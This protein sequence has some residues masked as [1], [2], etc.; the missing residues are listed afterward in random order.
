MLNISLLGPPASGKGTQAR[1][2][3]KHFGFFYLEMGGA[4]RDLAWRKDDLGKKVGRIVNREGTLVPDSIVKLVLED[5]F[6]KL[7]P[8]QGILIDGFP[9]VL[10]QIRLLNQSFKEIGRRLDFVILLDLPEKEV[11]KRITNRVVCQK[12][13]RIYSLSQE[14]KKQ[15]PACGGRLVKRFDDTPAGIKKRLEVFRK[16]TLPVINFY[17]REGILRK[18][19]GNQSVTKI[20]ERIAEIIKQSYDFD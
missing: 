5:S 4:L 12:C 19:N 14:T 11:L 13:G 17:R 15:C 16:E 3:V 8:K 7:K 2:L 10:S 9:R 20:T 6:K 1:I 18:V